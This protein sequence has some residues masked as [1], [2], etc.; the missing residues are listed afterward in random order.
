MFC[1]LLV[2]IIAAGMSTNSVF[3]ASDI[4]INGSTA[5]VYTSA[6]LKSALENPTIDKVEFANDIAVTNPAQKKIVIAPRRANS[7]LV[8]DGNGYK[9]TE[10]FVPSQSSAYGIKVNAK[11]NLSEITIKNMNIAGGNGYGTIQISVAGVTQNFEDVTYYGPKMAFNPCGDVNIKNCDITIARAQG[12]GNVQHEVA[13]AINITLSGDV[14]IRKTNE[15]CSSAALFAIKKA[16]GGIYVS[17]NAVVTINN[18][19]TYKGG[20]ANGCAHDFVIGDNAAFSYDGTRTFYGAC[21]TLA[22]FKTGSNSAVNINVN[23]KLEGSVIDACKTINIGEGTNVEIKIA[24]DN[25]GKVFYGGYGITLA[26][27]SKVNI[28][29]NGSNG[30]VTVY[31]PCGDIRINE[32]ANM[33]VNTNGKLCCPIMK[34]CKNLYVGN[35]AILDLIANKNS[36]KCCNY[37]FYAAGCGSTITYDKPGRV[38]FYNDALYSGKCKVSFAAFLGCKTIINFDIYSTKY[39]NTASTSGGPTVLA[40]PT[41][42]WSQ[43]PSNYQVNGVTGSCGKFASFNVT[44]YTNGNINPNQYYFGK[45]YEVCLWQGAYSRPN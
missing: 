34:I 16:G 40:N 19:S 43:T 41:Y 13:E 8:I 28:D 6:G 32:K 39:W 42:E 26:K 21:S 11:G 5:K 12:R 7:S 29:I 23:S 15:T 36:N 44:N 2:V 3:A 22:N 9:L 37:V 24:G 14:K 30:C 38:L 45:N 25:C 4:E 10:Y 31:A 18:E 35:N 33:T 1:T 17:D 27:E 20:F